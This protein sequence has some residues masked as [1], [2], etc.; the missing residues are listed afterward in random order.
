MMR[1]AQPWLGTVVEVTVGDETSNE[2]AMRAA[3]DVI[4]EVH[5][6][7]SFH[8]EA[9][10]VA[11]LNRAAIGEQ[12]EVHPRTAEVLAAA[13]AMSV[14]SEGLFNPFCAPK[15]V[16]WEQLPAPAAGP[17]PDWCAR[18]DALA[19]D[20]TRVRKNAPSWIDLGGI[21]KGYAVDAAVDALRGCGVRAGCVNAGGDLR[22]FGDIDW[23]VLLRDARRPELAA[24][25]T[26]LR[27]PGNFGH[28]FF[29]REQ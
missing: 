18:G 24:W 3:F 28:V 12:I 26:Q 7:M 21:A 23:P 10:D 29:A 14:E 13:L 19:L 6:L 16:A 4:A 8:D 27:D 20:G 9:S 15:L 5:R 2:P 17:A 25:S 11:R 1:R 22:A